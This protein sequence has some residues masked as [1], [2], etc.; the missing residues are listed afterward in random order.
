MPAAKAAASAR[1]CSWRL[2]VYHWPTSTTIAV[3]TMKTG[4]MIAAST[5]MPPRSSLRSRFT[6]T[7]RSFCSG[8]LRDRP[9]R[10][11]VMSAIRSRRIVDEP[12][13]VTPKPKNLMKLTGHLHADRGRDRRARRGR[14]EALGARV[15]SM[16]TAALSSNSFVRA[17]AVAL[18]LERSACRRYG[19]RSTTAQRAVS[20]AT[21][22][23]SIQ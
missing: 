1:F 17:L 10:V 8:G 16:Q 11:D 20:F 21:W 19:F 23:V 5:R 3:M 9:D 12:L 6:S 22:F 4:I 15:E 2:C 7:S 18:Q 13:I 14:L